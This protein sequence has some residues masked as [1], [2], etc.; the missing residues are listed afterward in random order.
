MQAVA[1]C[2]TWL[3][4]ADGVRTAILGACVI[5]RMNS[6]QIVLPDRK[7][8]RR[9]S[10]I[11]AHREREF[12]L[13]DLGSSNGTYLNGR[14]INQP[15]RLNDQDR[16]EIAGFSFTFHQ[17]QP[18][19]LTSTLG[20]TART[21]RDIRTLPCWLLVADVKSSTQF[22][23]RLPPD[24]F[25]FTL[26]TWL[27]ACKEL[28]ESHGGAINKFLGDGFFA[29]WVDQDQSPAAV[30]SALL[31]LKNLQAEDQPPFRFVLHYGKASLGGSASLGEESLLGLD[32]N[33]AFRMEKV[34]AEVGAPTLLSAEANA[35]LEPILQ[36]A[37]QGC[38][39]VPGFSGSFQFYTL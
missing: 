5:G 19:Q 38:H 12:W 10:I 22:A 6:N 21:I 29:F 18:S 15:S 1:E 13:I 16:I 34:A 33:F 11:H 27:V 8:S 32:V 2:E 30:A 39:P 7:V 37:Q 24:E 28:V 36:T 3:E 20:T 4:S 9:H 26:G 31:A 35:R 23:Q 17:S 25:S 14:R